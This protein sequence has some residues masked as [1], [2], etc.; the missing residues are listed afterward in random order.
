MNR[1]LIILIILISLVKYTALADSGEYAFVVAS[2]GTG[3]FITVQEAI[4]NVPDFRNNETVI[5]LKNGVYKE[6][7]I[8][9]ASKNNVTFIGESKDS[10]IIIYDD[11]ASKLNR[12][13]EEMGTTGSSGFFIFGNNFTARNIT[14]ENSAGPVGQAVAVR[15]SG[16]RI[17]FEN[18]NFL[19][20]QDT[21]YPHTSGS[22]QFYKNCY[23][24]GTVDFIFGWS[25]AWFEN[26]II[27]PKKRGYIT[28]AST[29]EDT[30]HGFV[31]NNCSIT[32]SAPEHSFYLG[33]PWRD[34]AQTVFINCYMSEV[35]HPAGWHNWNKPHAEETAFYAE[36]NSFGP[37]A[38]AEN[39]VSWSHQLTSEQV[40][41]Y[42]IENVL[43]GD[44]NWNPLDRITNTNQ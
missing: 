42:T 31:F 28:A 43:G 38:S 33:R 23:I 13:G 39:R 5:F 7:L 25:T 11:Y 41:K 19:G 16:D 10:T 12:F 44:D 6:K 36:Y 17:V 34:H 35:V 21:L 40:A 27:F 20:H 37:G 22:R 8:L 4:N 2:D 18:C 30:S 29:N 24:E 3:D 15:V 26:C 9:P 32:G 14:F 1:T